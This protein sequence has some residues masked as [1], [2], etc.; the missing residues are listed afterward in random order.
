MKVNGMNYENV[1]KENIELLAM[2]LF[3]EKELIVGDENKTYTM[4]NP[5]YHDNN[6]Q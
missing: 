5:Y 3:N 4:E 2:I 1:T 6:K